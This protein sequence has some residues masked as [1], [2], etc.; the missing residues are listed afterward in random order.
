MTT[1]GSDTPESASIN[2]SDNVFSQI[3]TTTHGM[4][5]E[6]DS[7]EKRFVRIIK[8]IN[9]E[10][11]RACYQS[12]LQLVQRE[13]KDIDMVF[14]KEIISDLLARNIIM[15]KSND[16]NKESFKIM[17]NSEVSLT[18]TQKVD[19]TVFPIQDVAEK[20]MQTEDGD[21]PEPLGAVKQVINDRFY[22][23]LRDMI[24]KEVVESLQNS[25]K[26]STIRISE[27]E[28][29]FVDDDI[30]MQS[31]VKHDVKDILIESLKSD[32]EFLRSE[33]RSKDKIIE[34]I[35]KD[36]TSN[37]K[38][39][40]NNNQLFP[41]D[42]SAIVKSNNDHDKPLNRKL[43]EHKKSKSHNKKDDAEN[44][45]GF[46]EQKKKVNTKRSVTVIGDS[47]VKEMKPYK[48][49]QRLENNE[50]IFI[51]T[52]AGATTSCMKDYVRPSL[53]YNPDAILL[54]CGT[55]DLRS[56][57]SACEIAGEIINLAKDMKST[58]NDVIISG[59]VV[60]N[61]SLNDKG[62]EVNTIIK[63]KCTENSFVFCDNSN[64]SGN[65]LNASGLHL[66]SKGTIALTN[67]F[68]KCL[69]Y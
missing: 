2:V 64:I 35:I 59:I 3:E 47:I 46:I 39:F 19:E 57:K 27:Q 36:N 26:H 1:D 4:E 48:M 66:N 37:Y 12:I 11:H 13:K 25:D 43:N 69:N 53:R 52:F 68:L 9:G 7:E 10:R 15:N 6:M 14:C 56:D 45:D 8:R 30:L 63:T 29:A 24:K 38:A 60:R 32:I 33:I 31:H 18:Q 40:H 44:R 34:L 28:K 50:K 5:A 17:D 58:E 49:R 23:V 41:P 54:H 55:N 22:Q 67:N 16:I 21:Q 51:K 65:H 61:D 62:L 20:I 42:N